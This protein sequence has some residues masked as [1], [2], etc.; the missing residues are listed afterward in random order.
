[1]IPRIVQRHFAWTIVLVVAISRLPA[2]FFPILTSGE[3]E[4]A[5]GAVVWMKGGVPYV[6]FVSQ[7]PLLIHGWY[8]GIFSI[9]GPYNM[10]A[11]HVLNILLVL[12]TA[13]GLYVI[14]R[15][16]SGEWV[17]RWA[18]IFYAFFQCFYSIGPFLASNTETLMNAFAVWGVYAFF[19]SMREDRPGMSL[20]A[21]S[22]MGFAVLANLMAVVILPACAVSMIWFWHE[23]SVHK[24][25]RY[26][27]EFFLLLAGMLFPIALYLAYLSDA[28]GFDGFFHWISGSAFRSIYAAAT[29][30]LVITRGLVQ[31]GRFLVVTAVLWILSLW[32]VI[33]IVRKRKWRVEVIFFAAWIV[34]NVLAIWVDGR[35]DMASYLIFMPSLTMLAAIA[36]IGKWE[37]FIKGIRMSKSVRRKIKIAATIL[38]LVVPYIA[39][40]VFHV[41]ELNEVREGSASAKKLAEFIKTKTENEDRIFV[42]GSAPELYFYSRRL[43]ASRFLDAR[44]LSGIIPGYSSRDKLVSKKQDLNAWIMLKEDFK[45]HVPALIVDLAEENLDGYGKFPISKQLFLAN[46]VRANYKRDE[47]VEGA[48]I[49]LRR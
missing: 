27:E 4:V 29:P 7:Y 14:A 49:Y 9:F 21:G 39:F 44:H 30:M 6:D 1:M 35:F 13:G 23:Q 47:A 5:V 32:I 11:V 17:A 37:F 41:T 43:P 25:H 2:L 18:C 31:L 26:F 46:Y 24:W 40:F 42:W 15:Y 38:M 10:I 34:F 19:K 48:E 20:V 3:S 28:G 45:R 12:A 36:L 33:D 8:R 16:T 22:L